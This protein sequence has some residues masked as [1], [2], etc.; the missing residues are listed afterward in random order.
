MHMKWDIL[1]LNIKRQMREK[2]IKYE[3]KYEIKYLIFF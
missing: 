1:F 3:I 2:Y